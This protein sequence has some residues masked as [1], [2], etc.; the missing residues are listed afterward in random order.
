MRS[1]KGGTKRL[2]RRRSALPPNPCSQQRDIAELCAAIEALVRAADS[3]AGFHLARE[4]DVQHIN[5]C[6]GR[7]SP[8]EVAWKSKTPA[9]QRAFVLVASPD[10][11]Q[12]AVAHWLARTIFEILNFAFTFQQP[13][14]AG[15]LF[16]L[17]VLEPAVKRGNTNIQNFR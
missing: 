10:A 13:V 4:G 15:A 14:G 17:C 5:S 8:C 1:N 16:V 2:S 11:A 7:S 3:G 9:I 6:C 12:D